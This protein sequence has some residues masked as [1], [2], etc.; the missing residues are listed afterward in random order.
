MIC[1]N[2]NCELVDGTA[3]W[4]RS[5]A[6]GSLTYVQ[7]LNASAAQRLQVVPTL[8]GLSANPGSDSSFSLTGSG[9]MEGSSMVWAT[10]PDSSRA[11]W[12]WSMA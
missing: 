9:F 7:T 5:I 1:P 8:S 6:N 11:A 4:S 12:A 10:W 2:C 3:V